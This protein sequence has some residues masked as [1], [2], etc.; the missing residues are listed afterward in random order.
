MNREMRKDL[1]Q[2]KKMMAKDVH[3]HEKAMHPGKPLTPMKKGGRTCMAEGGLT[4]DKREARTD[5]SDR[6][7]MRLKE[8]RRN[9]AADKF[10]DKETEKE[11][12]DQGARKKMAGGGIASAPPPRPRPVP[13][14]AAPIKTL[15]GDNKKPPMPGKSLHSV[16]G[17]KYAKGGPVKKNMHPVAPSGSP[18]KTGPMEKMPK[19]RQ[20]FAAGGVAKIRHNQATKAGKPTAGAQKK[21][22]NLI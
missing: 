13:L 12:Y 22:G 2:D 18:I 8:I 4:G 16:G 20:V 1:A 14:P 19:A 17:N 6:Y 11:L 15:M 21:F 7:L 5:F 3:K 9:N 10:L